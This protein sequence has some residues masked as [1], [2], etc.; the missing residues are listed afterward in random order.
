MTK[1][2]ALRIAKDQVTNDGRPGPVAPLLKKRSVTDGAVSAAERAEKARTIFDGIPEQERRE[3]I[4]VAYEKSPTVTPRSNKSATLRQSIGGRAAPPSSLYGTA[5]P[6]PLFSWTPSTDS[7]IA[8]RQSAQLW[9]GWHKRTT[10]R[11]CKPRQ[12]PSSVIPPPTITPRT[13]NKSA[14]LGAAKMEAEA[15]AAAKEAPKS[16]KPSPS[17][18]RLSMVAT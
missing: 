12:R 15:V 5:V 18:F 11:S 7:V 1:E 17:S 16:L 13:N 14:A 4:S 3:T 2:A 10:K 8:W 9:V 6:T